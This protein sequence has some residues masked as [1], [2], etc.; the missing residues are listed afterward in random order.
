MN[1]EKETKKMQA[2]N[3]LEGMT[4]ISALLNSTCGNNRTIERVWI[5]SSKRKSK[6]AEIG[7][8]TAKSKELGFEIAFV[9][10][11]QIAEY[12]LGSTHGGILAFC[13]DRILPPLE[14]DFIRDGGFYVYLEGVEDPYNF[15]YTLRSLYAAGVDGVVLPERNWMSAAGVV[16]R[17]SAG[18]SELFPMFTADADTVARVFH[19]KKYQILCAGIRDSVSVFDEDLRFPILLVIGGEKRGISRNLLDK[20]DKIVRIDYGRSFRGS[21]SAASAA[22]VMAFEIFRKNKTPVD[23]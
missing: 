11:E 15:G 13:S 7:F 18:T 6:A 10:S 3:V 9:S 19:E 12:S 20:A 2:S 8:L 14:A 1:M 23:R 17:A 22:T 5:D 4:S 21:L 16:A